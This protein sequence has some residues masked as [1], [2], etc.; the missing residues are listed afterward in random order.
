MKTKKNRLELL[1]TN[2][3]IIYW[4]TNRTYLLVRVME[5][6]HMNKKSLALSFHQFGEAHVIECLE[7]F[8]GK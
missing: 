5:Q 4:K 1:I 7:R 2:Y 3:L 6:Y 8:C